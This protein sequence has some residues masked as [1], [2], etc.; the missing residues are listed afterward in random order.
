MQ[1]EANPPCACYGM[2]GLLCGN[3]R[4]ASIVTASMQVLTKIFNINNLSASVSLPL[5][6]GAVGSSR[7]RVSQE[8][9]ARPSD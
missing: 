6:C 5:Y 9:G 2:V 7:L 1:Q 3:M 4:T 8:V